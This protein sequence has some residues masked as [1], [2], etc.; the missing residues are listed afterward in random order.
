[1]PIAPGPGFWRGNGTALSCRRPKCPPAFRPP[2]CLMED[3]PECILI[4]EDDVNIR[5]L[6]GKFLTRRGYSVREAVNG[7][8]GLAAMRAGDA[9]LVVLDLMMPEVDGWEVLRTRFSDE[10]LRA[11]PVVVVSAN[12][13][14][15]LKDVLDKGIC[16]LL[17]KPFDLDALGA[18]IKSCLSHPHGPLQVLS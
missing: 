4:V 16:A 11:I 3:C 5:R 10:H 18:V 15:D 17:P 12:T 2:A 6:V 7:R 9:S 13:G 8:E 1:M 14:P